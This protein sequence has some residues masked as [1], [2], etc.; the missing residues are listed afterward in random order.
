MALMDKASSTASKLK[1]GPHHAIERF[2]VMFIAL[3]AMGALLAVTTAVSAWSSSR[4]D[5]STTAVYTPEFVTSLTDQSGELEGVYV[6]E[7]RTTA[8]ALMEFDN[9]DAFSS[10]ADNYQAF[11][12]GASS[13]MSG[14]D[15]ATNVSGNVVMFGSSGYFGV[16]LDSDEPFEEQVLNLTMRSNTDVSSTAEGIAEDTY[17]SDPTFAEYDQWRLFFN[18]G[19]SEAEE[20]SALNPRGVDASAIFAQVILAEEEEEARQQMDQSLLQMQTQLTLIEDLEDE[21][22]RVSVG[23]GVSIVPPEIPEHIAYDEIT[24]EVDQVEMDEDGIEIVVEGGDMELSTDYVDPRGFDFD[25]REGSIE[26]GYLDALVPD[27]ETYQSYLDNKAAGAASGL[28]ED[29]PDEEEERTA[30]DSP[31]DEVG[32][33]DSIEGAAQASDDS[34]GFNANDLEWELTNGDDLTENVDNELY[35]PLTEVMNQLSQ[36]YQDYYDTKQQYQVEQY[37][38]LLSLEAQ[39]SVVDSSYS[40][41][42]DE[43]SVQV[44]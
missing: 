14:E 36:A 35:N 25:W 6:S 27:S 18:P 34:T 40:V 30:L 10:N 26:E 20:I 33:D 38:E 7:D 39:L 1:L 44:Y 11:L 8:L 41:N 42:S 17:S 4:A 5:F 43:D 9:P 21:M 15:V 12:T 37:M 32:T 24:G 13:D 23:D 31:E 29:V 19:A 3:C 22:D 28:S 2:G 16:M